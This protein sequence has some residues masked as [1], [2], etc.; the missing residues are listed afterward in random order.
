MALI[1]R[2]WYALAVLDK[3]QGHLFA[4]NLIPAGSRVLVGYSGGADSTCLVHL[5]AQ[6]KVDFVAAHLHH[7][8]RTDADKE[9]A[10]SEAF[11][12]SLD[13][14]FVSGRAD[15]PRMS[16]DLKI[17]LEEAG[18]MARYNFLNQAAKRFECDLVATAH[19]GTDS[20][21]TILFNLV[22]GTGPSGLTGIDSSRNGLI[23]PLLPFSRSETLAYCQENGLW[24]H[25]DPA[26]ESMDFSRARLRHRVSPE[27]AL[28]NPGYESAI[29]RCASII[30]EENQFLN[31]AAANALERAEIPLN[32]PLGFL[33][34]DAEVA[35]DR[36]LIGSLPPVLFKRACRLAVS[37]L[38]ASIDFEQTEA[39]TSGF[40]S[41]VSGSVTSDGGT[42]VAEWDEKLLHFRQLQPTE[43]FRFMLTC[44]GETESEEFGWKI[45]AHH[46]PRTKKRNDRTALRVEVSI[47]KTQGELYFRSTQ[48]G[49]SMQPLGFEGTRKLSDLLSEA[50]LTKAA[51]SRLPIICDFVGPIWAPGVCLSHRIDK[52][53]EC[54]R[55]LALEF[56]PMIG[57][58]QS[59]N[60]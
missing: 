40:G 29:L 22:R 37:A 15:V 4:A 7:G 31:G 9:M 38:G 5:L 24:F 52:E 44:P 36:E 30:S 48:P 49:D 34:R 25:N 2:D 33:T 57:S 56:E 19:T 8:Q 43:P 32:G 60:D 10:L 3:L 42:V 11:C 13:V 27:L 51:R 46:S 14:P 6:L 59:G 35:F 20:V 50:K 17:G 21:E 23:R 26:N 45:T 47:A 16:R 12:Q 54:E 41:G 28:V 58:T 53:P 55:V 1:I 18:R 39:I